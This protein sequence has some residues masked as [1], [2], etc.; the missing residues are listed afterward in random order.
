MI[1]ENTAARAPGQ[2]RPP[3]TGRRIRSASSTTD[4]IKW[5]S[6]RNGWEAKSEPPAQSAKS[7]WVRCSTVPS[8]SAGVD[9]QSGLEVRHTISRSAPRSTGRLPWRFLN[10]SVGVQQSAHGPLKERS[11]TESSGDI[12]GITQA[13]LGATALASGQVL[14]LRRTETPPRRQSR[15]DQCDYQDRWHGTYRSPPHRFPDGDTARVHSVGARDT[16]PVDSRELP[17]RRLPDPQRD[18][19]AGQQ[20]RTAVAVDPS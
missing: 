18:V 17:R 20:R 16:T 1:N 4:R 5:S 19:A 3:G 13:M 10:P 7:S 8:S 14:A 2:P 9:G 11:W 6:P 15:R 12:A